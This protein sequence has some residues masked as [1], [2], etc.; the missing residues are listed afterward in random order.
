MKVNENL[1]CSIKIGKRYLL[2]LSK[3]VLITGKWIN[4]L[5]KTP[6]L[7]ETTSAFLLSTLAALS[8]LCRHSMFMDQG[9]FSF[10]NHSELHWEFCALFFLEI[11]GL[12][13]F[14]ENLI[15]EEMLYVRNLTFYLYFI[16]WLIHWINKTI[17]LPLNQ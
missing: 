17:F 16:Y 4:F 14:S 9:F 3:Y 6:R 5:K 7:S 11:V 10:Y 15:L 12:K 13:E 8:P 1:F 2:V